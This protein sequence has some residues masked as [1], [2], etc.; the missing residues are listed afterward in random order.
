MSCSQGFWI[1]THLL[2]RMKSS[3]MNHTAASHNERSIQGSRSQW[4]VKPFPPA[5]TAPERSLDLHISDNLEEGEVLAQI[6]HRSHSSS[7]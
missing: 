2:D 1:T 6:V 4:L 5:R 3:L 7:L